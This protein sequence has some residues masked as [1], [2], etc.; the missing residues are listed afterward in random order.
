M[1]TIDKLRQW[2]SDS[3]FS[4]RVLAHDA[5]VI[6][7]Q[8]KQTVFSVYLKKL[9]KGFEAEVAFNKKRQDTNTAYAVLSTK[10]SVAKPKTSHQWPRVGVERL[11]SDVMDD[12]RDVF[13]ECGHEF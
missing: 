6:F 7:L 11:T 5:G 13:L 1:W 9:D 10:Y 8:G 4:T 3:K 2:G 12:V